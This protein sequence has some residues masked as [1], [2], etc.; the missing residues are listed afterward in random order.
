MDEFAAVADA[1]DGARTRWNDATADGTA[2]GLP[3]AVDAYLLMQRAWFTELGA[4]AGAL[5]AVG[6]AQ[7]TEPADG[8]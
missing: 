4:Q 5:R 3:V 6:A 1:L 2:C 7:R 8:S